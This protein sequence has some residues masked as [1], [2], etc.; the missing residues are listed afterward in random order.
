MAKGEEEA[1]WVDHAERC[2]LG[3][4]RKLVKAFGG[5]TTA[6][7]TFRAR[8]MML[9]PAQRARLEEAERLAR[10]EVGAEKRRWMLHAAIAA[11]YVSSFGAA[12]GAAHNDDA[13]P[14]TAGER[15]AL[16]EAWTRH[17]RETARRLGEVDGNPSAQTASANDD[18]EGGNPSAQTATATGDAARRGN[19]SAQTTT[20]TG[21]AP[22]GNPSAPDAPPLP[23]FDPVHDPHALRDRLEALG[24]LLGRWWRL[25]AEIATWFKRLELWRHLDAPSFQAYCTER[26]RLCLRAVN[27]HIRFE[28]H[29]Q[30]LP[31]LRAAL[32]AGTLDF[33]RA[34]AIAE[35]AT[36]FDIDDRIAEAA[37][38]PSLDVQ[39]EAEAETD[40][41]LSAQGKMRL[42]GPEDAA[43]LL[44]DA[45]RRA[46]ALSRARGEP[47]I[48]PGEAFAR[49][50]DHFVEVW[51]VHGRPPARGRRARV[52]ARCG[53]IC[54]VPECSNAAHHL[55][56]IIFRARGGPD[57]DWNLVGICPF[58][59]LFA[60]HE[61]HMRVTGRAG[62]CLVWEIGLHQDVPRETYLSIL[63]KG[64]VRVSAALRDVARRAA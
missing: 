20:A 38:R 44:D 34:C 22:S 54:E 2:T 14:I 15:K 16:L 6:D 42:F 25:F 58:H 41:N 26:L 18:A 33:T 19:P 3:A 49:V 9:D 46:M 62:E 43:A 4:L 55:H 47:P 7:E 5:T 61:G 50:C 48:T 12:G 31:Q 27:R 10:R 17:L 57:E 11:E 37:D 1:I 52:L 60:I 23:D 30:R 63:G 28:R 53:G 40:G 51:S 56:H 35:N 32:D 21:D 36:A 8:M 45:I 59:H 29:L 13:E 39:Q 24:A 64:P